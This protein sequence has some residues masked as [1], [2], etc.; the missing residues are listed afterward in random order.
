MILYTYIEGGKTMGLFSR[1]EICCI[2][3]QEK[4]KRKI[5]DG[6]SC[7]SCLKRTRHFIDVQ[8]PLKKMTRAMI[9][10]AMER[11]KEN[12]KIAETFNPTKTV[13]KYFQVDEEKK[14]WR[15]T[16]LSSDSIIYKFS[17]ILEYELIEDG[18]SITKGG[19]GSAVAGG[20]LFGATGAVVGGVTGKKTTQDIVKR[21]EIK[22]TMNDMEHPTEYIHFLLMEQK[23][24]SIIYR[25]AIGSAE[26]VLSLLALIVKDNEL[27]RGIQQQNTVSSAD[28]ILKYKN[29]LDQGIITQ[30]EFEAKKKQLLEL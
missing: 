15:I 7:Q 14:L 4:G 23:K 26:Q 29:L 18:N 30:E 28:E 21:L 6:W 17:D 1:K 25:N 12:E 16:N 3:N 20:V 22:I 13:G 8:I 24:S 11:A 2:C 9:L 10:E 5:A 27:S 19:V